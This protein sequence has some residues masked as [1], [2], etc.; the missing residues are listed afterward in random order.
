MNDTLKIPNQMMFDLIVEQLNQNK[1]TTF[2]VIGDSMLPFFKNGKTQV[3]L[4]KK[5]KYEKYDVV[6]FKYKKQVLLHRIIKIVGDMFYIQGDGAY[7]IEKVKYHQ[8][9]GAVLDFNTNQ[10]KIKHYKFKYKLWLCLKPIRKLL[11]KRFH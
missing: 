6:L 5:E 4:K 3:T 8:I 2:T 7:R 10:T 11:L 1:T 9:Y